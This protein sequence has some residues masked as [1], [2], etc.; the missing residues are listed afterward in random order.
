MKRL[1]KSW[2]ISNTTATAAQELRHVF[3]PEFLRAVVSY[4]TWWSCMAIFTTSAFGVV[5]LHVFS[6]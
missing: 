5:Y 4:F 3:V 6:S 2:V 1:Q